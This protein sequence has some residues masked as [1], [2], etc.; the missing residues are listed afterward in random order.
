MW[1]RWEIKATAEDY[2]VPDSRFEE[3]GRANDLLI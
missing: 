2:R 3:T 1:T